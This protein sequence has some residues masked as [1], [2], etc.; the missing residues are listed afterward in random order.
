MVPLLRQGSYEGDKSDDQRRGFQGQTNGLGFASRSF[1][2]LSESA[3]LSKRSVSNSQA[4]SLHLSSDPAC[5]AD[6][7]RWLNNLDGDRRR[8]VHQKQ[9]GRS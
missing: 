3:T 7:Y 1:I 9:G 5:E 2:R 4:W 6:N 8:K